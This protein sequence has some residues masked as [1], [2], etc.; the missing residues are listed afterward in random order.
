MQCVEEESG[1]FWIELPGEDE[2]HTYMSATWTES[3]SSS[4]GM[5]KLS[6]EAGWAFSAMRGPCRFL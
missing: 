5:V 6:G 3:A 2:A 1:D 4:T